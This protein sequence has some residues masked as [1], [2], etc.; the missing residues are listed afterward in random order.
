MDKF[1]DALVNAIS[2]E[3]WKVRPIAS[4]SAQPQLLSPASQSPV[5]FGSDRSETPASSGV[6]PTTE[7]PSATKVFSTSSAGIG[8]LMRKTEGEAREKQAVLSEAMRDINGVMSNATTI[9][10]E[11]NSMN[12]ALLAR[13]QASQGTTALAGEDAEA[14]VQLEAMQRK[15]GL[16]CPVSQHMVGSKSSFHAEV[17][18]ELRGWMNREGNPLRKAHVVS[19]IELYSLYNRARGGLD[20]LSPLD[21][22][23]ACDYLNEHYAEEFRVVKYPSGLTVLQRVTSHETILQLLTTLLGPRPERLADAAHCPDGLP[24]VTD[25]MVSQKMKVSLSVSRT[26]LE[27]LELDEVLC[28]SETIIGGLSFHWNIFQMRS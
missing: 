5:V 14:A 23:K 19:L 3:L 21:V 8:G 24:A 1:H 4:S 12:R 10:E 9:V 17:A 25:A 16:A 28:R 7:Q 11:I 18:K 6:S 2:R 22:R 13:G 20:L 27:D 15:L 26:I